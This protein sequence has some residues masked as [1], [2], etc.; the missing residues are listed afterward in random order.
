[1]FV[2][3]LVSGENYKYKNVAKVLYYLSNNLEIRIN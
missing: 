2:L 3:I 1:M